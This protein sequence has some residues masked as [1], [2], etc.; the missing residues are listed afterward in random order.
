MSTTARRLTLTV[1]IDEALAQN[2]ELIALRRQFEA[3]QE[4]PAQ[5]RFLMP[6]SFEAQIWQWP[7]T[8]INPL[9]TNMYMFTI[10]QELPGRGK[11]DRGANHRRDDY[12]DHSRTHHYAG[13]LLHREVACPQTRH[14]AT[15]GDGN[16]VAGRHMTRTVLAFVIPTLILTIT[17]SSPAQTPP[18]MA[19]FKDATCGCCSKWVEHLRKQ[20]VD[21]TATDVTNLEEVKTKNRVPPQMKS[22]HTATVGGYVIEGHVP[23]A[24]VHR[25][26]K[27]KPKGVIGLAVPGMPMGSPGMEVPGGQTQSYKVLAFDKDGRTTVFASH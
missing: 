7:V 20:G 24:D 12:L 23:A 17:S 15:V 21:A 19:V 25:L 3:A 1:A 18:K 11:P 10:Q 6:P 26:L 9:N 8:T 16:I 5:E 27:E 22:C 2:P 13:H 4:R 14:A